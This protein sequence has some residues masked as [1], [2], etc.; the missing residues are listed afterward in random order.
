MTKDMNYVKHKRGIKRRNRFIFKLCLCLFCF[1]L[2]VLMGCKF[3]G[4]SLNIDSDE[5]LHYRENGS[6]QYSVCLKNNDFFEAANPLWDASQNS[7]DEGKNLSFNNYFM[8]EYFLFVLVL[9]TREIMIIVKWPRL[10]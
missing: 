9:M 6:V 8:A 7:R 5:K 1:G 3:I 10:R 4:S 2:C